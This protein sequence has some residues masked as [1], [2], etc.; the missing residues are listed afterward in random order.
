M[1]FNCQLKGKAK[2]MVIESGVGAVIQEFGVNM[3]NAS[4]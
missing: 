2:K 1:C 3:G 4:A